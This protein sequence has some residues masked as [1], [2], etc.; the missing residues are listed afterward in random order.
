[1]SRALFL[2]ASFALG[3]LLGWAV[4]FV[5]DLAIDAGRALWALR[6]GKTS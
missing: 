5:V 4:C 6:K 1:M 3:F 2:L